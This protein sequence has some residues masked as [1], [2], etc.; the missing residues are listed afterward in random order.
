MQTEA[1][2]N[3]LNYDRE[4]L[5]QDIGAELNLEPYRARQV[6]SWIYRKSETSFEKMSDIARSAREEL[7]SRYQI[8]F[9]TISSVEQSKD[10]AR[11]YLLKLQDGSEVESVLIKQ[12][13][14]WTLCISSQVGCAIGC[15]FCRTALMGLKR[16]LET[17]EIIGQVMTVKR[18]AASLGLDSKP[19]NF[20][21][22]VFMGMGEPLHNYDNVTRAV[23]ILND[24]LG[25]SFGPR[26]ITVS[27]SGLV[28]AINK[29][30][31]S[32]V[33]A[34]LAI[35]LNATTDETRSKLIPINKKYPLSLL[36]DTLKMGSPKKRDA[37][38]IEYVM[39]HGVNDTKE[40]LRRIPRLLQGINAKLNLIPYN[41]NAGLGFESP[42][43][44]WVLHWQ[45]TLAK[46][47][48]NTRVRWSKGDDISAACGQLA[49]ESAKK[50][51]VKVQ[52]EASNV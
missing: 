32:N 41:S 14:R 23:S 30:V 52:E 16:H 24:D 20:A 1:K 21:N 33:G 43:R 19:E 25:L 34:K 18:D 15:K 12:A 26:K 35:S 38:T 7:D 2:L 37:Y 42:P 40:D 8:A 27:T 50:K 28:P 10:G 4:L 45:Q 47:G 5:S 48:I 46:E 22:I 13:K 9:P 31:A 17:A 29:F 51:S 44:E 6:I 49:T 3:I 36:L 39:L 11:K